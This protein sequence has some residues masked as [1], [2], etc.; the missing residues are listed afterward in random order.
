M[1]TELDRHT[2]AVEEA[3]AT[4]AAGRKALLNEQGRPI[5]APEERERREQ[6]LR[7]AFDRTIQEAGAAADAVMAEAQRELDRPEGDPLHALT[8]EELHLA[9]LRREFVRENCERLPLAALNGHV[10][11][12]LDV[13]DKASR[14]LHWR[15]AGERLRELGGDV[16]SGR[17]LGLDPTTRRQVVT[18]QTLVERLEATLVDV[19]KRQAAEAGARERQAA[20]ISVVGKAAVTQYIT[21]TYGAGRR[22]G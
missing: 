4:L 18:L 21:N 5:Y 22:A 9:N 6:E 13:G 19:G 3:Q 12:A 7:V 15:Y 10:E 1:S 14:Y 11:Q 2:R 8:P 17:V 20:A 16:L